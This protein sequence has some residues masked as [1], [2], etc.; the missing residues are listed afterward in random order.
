MAAVNSN[1]LSRK[2]S[3]AVHRGD[4][5]EVLSLITILKKTDENLWQECSYY[6]LSDAIKKGHRSV[7][8]LLLNNQA[9]KCP[10]DNK[11]ESA[12]HLAVENDEYE[13][14]KLLLEQGADVDEVIKSGDYQGST[15]L[16]VAFV[17]NELEIV[18]LLLDYGVN[19]NAV[20]SEIKTC[21]FYATQL[22]DLT[23]LEL[24]LRN[25]SD[26]KA[27]DLENN[28]A[29]FNAVSSTSLASV[30]LFLHY[31]AQVSIT[32][33]FLMTPL[34]LAAQNPSWKII[35]SLIMK[36]GNVNA[37]D[38]KGLT[39]LHTAILQGFV[40]NIKCL[41]IA[42]A[43]VNARDING[44]TPL[45]YAV[46]QED[47]EDVIEELLRRNADVNCCDNNGLKPLHSAADAAFDEYI[48]IL[49]EFGADIEAID[50]EGR[51]AL[52]MT[53]SF[54][55][56]YH[57]RWESVPLMFKLF[58]DHIFKMQMVDLVVGEENLKIINEYYGNKIDVTDSFKERCLKEIEEMKRVKIRTTGISYFDILK[59]G[60][61]QVARYT[62]IPGIEEAFKR[63]EYAK[64]FPLYRG[65]LKKCFDCAAKRKQVL[66]L[67]KYHLLDNVFPLVPEYCIDEIIRFLGDNDLKTFIEA[68]Y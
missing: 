60:R 26:L 1:I 16:H 54:D 14:A 21:I 3:N 7:A 32:N 5:D 19:I 25:G 44:E 4:Y 33:K 52:H 9:K 17:N 46:Q 22:T 13:I 41:L 63:F 40:G 18:Q 28:T 66:V 24:L 43:D 68:C 53:D 15:L 49:L 31:E 12:L 8:I 27:V 67:D 50:N 55:N 42:G 45:N 47:M 35:E 37:A 20:D 29:L 34:H 38:L 11:G 51:T 57:L 62:M 48:E 58:K 56:D 36:G 61:H 30:N 23:M 10:N 6:L 64:F 65:I 39:P 59:K 2:L